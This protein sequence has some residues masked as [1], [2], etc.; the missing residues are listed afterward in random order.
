[1]VFSVMYE[2]ERERLDAL[3]R[4]IQ[5]HQPFDQGALREPRHRVVGCD[6]VSDGSAG[7]SGD[8]GGIPCSL[9]S[10]CLQLRVPSPNESLATCVREY[11]TTAES[12]ANVEGTRSA[13]HGYS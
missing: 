3:L 8:L 7:I 10:P 11:R 4:G 13:I 5:I 12:S 6:T 9:L 1:M 2:P